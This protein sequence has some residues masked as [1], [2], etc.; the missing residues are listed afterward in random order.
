MLDARIPPMLAY[1]AP[2]PF[3]SK[4][5]LFEIKWDG[6]RCLLFQ[7]DGKIRLQNRRLEPITHRYPELADLP[8]SLH[9]QNA[10]LDGELVVLSGGLPN[11]SRL[12]QREQLADPVK[13]AL[14]SRT[15]PAAYVVFDILWLNGDLV[16]AL[17]LTARKELLTGILKESPHLIESQFIL[18]KGRTFFEEVVA[19][20]LEGV[21]AKTLTG[22]YLIGRRSRAWLKIKPRLEKVCAVM[23]YTQG[24]GAR[25]GTFGALLLATRKGE[26]WQYRGKVGSGF[27]GADLEDLRRRLRELE[28]ASPPLAHPPAVRGVKWVRP[29]L[30][31]RVSYQEETGRGHF[32]APVF[33]RLEDDD[34]GLRR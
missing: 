20:G 22:P 15:I 2:S 16:T 9:S 17:P 7:N 26:A 14:L 23:G 25:Q 18:E 30:W 1:A 34:Q 13:I 28:I 5:H 12:Q 11:F 21:M 29:E 27:T 8:R 10:I 19:R 24:S 32:R 3:D 31:V 6:T 33:M 4:R